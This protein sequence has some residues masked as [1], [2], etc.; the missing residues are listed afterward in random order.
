MKII[1]LCQLHQDNARTWFYSLRRGLIVCV[2]IYMLF[3]CSKKKSGTGS[4]W[5]DCYLRL[6]YKAIQNVLKEGWRQS[7]IESE[8]IAGL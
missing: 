2:Y 5:Q 3:A 1:S 4:C 8:L 7:V 6:S